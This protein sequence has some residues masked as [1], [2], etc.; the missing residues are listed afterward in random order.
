MLPDVKYICKHNF[1]HT[2]TTMPTNLKQLAQ[3]LNLSIATISRALQDSHEVSTETKQKVWALAKELNYEPNPYASSLRR[4]KSKT[5]AVIIPEIA[6]NFFTLA[7]NGIEEVANMKGYHVLIYLT[8]DSFEKE[9]SIVRHLQSGRVDGILISICSETD[10]REH[11]VDLINKNI[12]IVFFDRVFEDIHTTAKVTTDDYQSGFNATQHLI[13]S[14]CRRIS[15]LQISKK[16]SIGIK[17]LEGY[18]HALNENNIPFD[19]SLVINGS[20]DSH[21]NYDLVKELLSRPDRPDGIFASV[22]SL[23]ITT[24]YVC[25]DLGLSI[26]TD[27]KIISFSNLATAPLLCPSLT[28]ITQPAFEIGKEASSILFQKL[29]KNSF[30][31]NDNVVLNSSLTVR[32]ST[33]R[34]D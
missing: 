20:N 2:Y 32:D 15:Y 8:H 19:E 30:L 24:Y 1:L 11:L 7:I 13:D 33:K 6:N 16:L 21:G 12:P 14:G 23:A 25:K 22:E 28:T 27:V 26:P 17:R 9:V 4:Q 10:S 5:I 29:K 3:E 34:S 18:L 31:L